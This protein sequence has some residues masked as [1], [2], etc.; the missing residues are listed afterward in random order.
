MLETLKKKYIS[1]NI[2]LK[3]MSEMLFL[4]IMILK[5]SKLQII[6]EKKVNYAIYET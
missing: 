6:G 2:L 4:N 1:I 5:T 3:T